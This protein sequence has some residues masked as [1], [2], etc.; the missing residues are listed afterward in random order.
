[1]PTLWRSNYYKKMLPILDAHSLFGEIIIIDNNEKEVD[2]SIF[3]LKKIRY[4]KQEENIFVNPAW[5]LGVKLSKFD[6]ICLYSDDVFF[7]IKCLEEVYEKCVSSNGIIGFSLETISE[8]HDHLNFLASWEMSQVVATPSMH[9]RYGICM[10]M[11][12]ESYFYIP[13]Q[14]KIYYG[15]AFLF[16]QNILNN[17][18]NYKISGCPVITKMRSSSNSEEFEIITKKDAEEYSKINPT[19]ELILNL[20]NDLEKQ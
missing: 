10:F 14:L 5:N 17:K 1:M 19:E 7:D 16:D 4:L 6:K 11:H 8:Q 20:M 3:S 9:Y 18:Q 13:E 2:Q 12:K 15:D